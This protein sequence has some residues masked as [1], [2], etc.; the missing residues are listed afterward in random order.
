MKLKAAIIGIM[1]T[2]VLI[3]SA[4]SRQSGFPVLKGPYLGQKPPGDVPE[5][6]APQIFKTSVIDYTPT[7]SP[8]GNE[9]YWAVLF[10]D[11]TAGV[12]LFIKRINDNWTEPQVASFS[13]QYSDGGPCFSPDGTKLFFHSNRPISGQ[14]EPKDF[15]I[16]FVERT[17]SGWSE[18]INA[19]RMVNTE[20][21]ERWH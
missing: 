11:G 5:L 9:I 7:L 20:K 14:G 13:G 1:V 17:E 16:W 21:L 8:N 12:I 18:P 10:F 3:L 15:D 2:L 6:F 4:C 19:G